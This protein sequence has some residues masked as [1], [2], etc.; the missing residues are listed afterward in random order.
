MQYA[1]DR[2]AQSLSSMGL[3]GMSAPFI[4]PEKLVS[5]PQGKGMQGSWTDDRKVN[6]YNMGIR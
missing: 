6:H 4:P 3:V 2:R 1:Q 5:M